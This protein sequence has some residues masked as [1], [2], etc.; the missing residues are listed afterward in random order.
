MAVPTPDPERARQIDEILAT[1]PPG[2]V[3]WRRRKLEDPDFEW[4]RERYPDNVADQFDP[5][6][7]PIAIAHWCELA[8]PYS[9]ASLRRQAFMD[10]LWGPGG[11]AVMTDLD[12]GEET[13][14]W[15]APGSPRG[16]APT[17]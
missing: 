12:T 13:A 1:A 4:W 2:Y 16:A 5:D 8:D 7:L 6:W 15:E 17:N 3:E 11:T 9:E 14:R 10:A